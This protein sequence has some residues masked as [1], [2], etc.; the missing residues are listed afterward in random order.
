MLAALARLRD[1]NTGE[2]SE[3]T[4]EDVRKGQSGRNL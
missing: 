3:H 4:E 1:V 2:R